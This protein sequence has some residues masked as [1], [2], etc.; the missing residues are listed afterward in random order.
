M[1]NLNNFPDIVFHIKSFSKIFKLSGGNE[2]VQVLCPYCDDSTRHGRTSQSHGHMYLS[3]SF[4]FF[5]CHRCSMQ[6][7]LLKLLHDSH[8]KNTKILDELKTYSNTFT[9]SA[10][11]NISNDR[12]LNFKSQIELNYSNFKSRHYNN[13]IRYD[14]YIYSRILDA[15]PLDFYLEP[16]II[17]NKLVCS[18]SNF[19]GKKISARYIDPNN[20]RYFIYNSNRD[21]YYFQ[22]ISKLMS[23]KSIVLCE[24][25]FDLIN[26]YNYSTEFS[27]DAFYISIG[28]SNYTKIIIFLLNNYLLLSQHNIN[29]VFDKNVI[30]KEKI[31]YSI[32]ALTAYLNPKINNFFY[33]PTLTKDVSEL[34]FL[35]SI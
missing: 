10:K 32:R 23:Y 22:D 35:R 14:N 8:F 16:N 12:L 27:T 20:L 17:E 31:I 24:G 3:I 21:F 5:I 33:E 18:I 28:G 7:G 29:I 30:E 11:Y 26:L 1:F 34:M 25:A 13:K 9:H 6:G 4:P 2:W 15:N 19:N